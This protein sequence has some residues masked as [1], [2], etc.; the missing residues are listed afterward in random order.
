MD[1]TTDAIVEFD[2]D[3]VSPSNRSTNLSNSMLHPIAVA[4]VDINGNVN[5]RNFVLASK[6]LQPLSRRSGNNQH[7][8]PN[9]P[10]PF[11]F[12]VQ[13]RD[14]EYHPA[15]RRYPVTFT[16]TAGGGTLSVEQTETNSRGRAKSSLT[17]GPNVGINT[18]EV[19]VAGIEGTVIFKR[20]GGSCGGLS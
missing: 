3:G 18:V 11:P 17:L 10:L 16:V 12:V 1:G 15:T 19:S 4:A 13:V 8:L 14:V 5:R 6:A 2:Y 7:G 20:C 9:T